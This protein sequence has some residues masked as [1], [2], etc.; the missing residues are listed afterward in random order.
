M[1]GRGPKNAQ[2]SK[3]ATERARLYAARTSWHEGQISRRVRDNAVAGIIGGLIIVGAVVS[4]SVHAA[5]TAPEPEPTQTSTPTP[6]E[7]PF[8]E[9][10]SPE[11]TAQ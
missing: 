6:M 4:Q 10:F 1:A 8:S 5:V 7:N 2:R 11:G 9:L 3:A